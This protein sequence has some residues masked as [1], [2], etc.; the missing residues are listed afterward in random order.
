MNTLENLEI[1]TQ[2]AKPFSA[3]NLPKR[4]PRIQ[5]YSSL[6]QRQIDCDHR[7][8]RGSKIIFF[9]IKKAGNPGKKFYSFQY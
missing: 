7:R 3:V 4:S 9:L 2:R 8:T 1:R 5:L 6:L